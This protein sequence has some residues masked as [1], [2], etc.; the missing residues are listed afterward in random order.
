MTMT[1]T[2]AEREAITRAWSHLTDYAMPS[3]MR[4]DLEESARLEKRAFNEPIPQ[5]Q[6][7]A[8]VVN[9]FWKGYVDPSMPI[10]QLG[11]TRH[12]YRIAV[13]TGADAAAR[14]TSVDEPTMAAA[15]AAYE[16]ASHRNNGVLQAA[17]AQSMAAYKA[18]QG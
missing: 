3:G 18:A 1:F 4:H 11:G 7:R 10:S 9:W 2:K 12:A 6:A 5:L 16:A 8:M 14:S 13:S 17:F 15:I